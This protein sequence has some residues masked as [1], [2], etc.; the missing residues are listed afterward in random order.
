MKPGADAQYLPDSGCECLWSPFSRTRWL[1][2][3][4]VEYMIGNVGDPGQRRGVGSAEDSAWSG[5][6]MVSGDGR[7]L[8]T[9]RLS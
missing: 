8:K 3:H 2:R 6:Q 1:R 4:S 5:V 7:F 9:I